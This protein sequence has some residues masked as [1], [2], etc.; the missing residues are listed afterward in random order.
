MKMEVYIMINELAIKKILRENNGNE[1]VLR[2]LDLID[3]LGIIFSGKN[4]TSYDDISLKVNL[5]IDTGLLKDGMPKGES[6]LD[7]HEVKIELWEI[8]T[9]TIGLPIKAFKKYVKSLNYAL[10]ELYEIFPTLK[11]N[12]E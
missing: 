4:N 8:G 7:Y 2:N 10:D 9:Y 3:G 1:D 6:H 11:E 12:N 5:E